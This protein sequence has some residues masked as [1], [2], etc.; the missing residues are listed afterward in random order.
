MI[1]QLDADGSY[2]YDEIHRIFPAE[3]FATLDTIRNVIL[4][5]TCRFTN[6]HIPSLESLHHII[7]KADVNHLRMSLFEQ[8][9]GSGFNWPDLVAK[10]AIRCISN[11]LGQDYLIQTKANL[12][13]QMPF[14]ETS[15]LDI[16]SDC[17]SGDS[18]WQLN[19]WIPL[20][21]STSSAS[22]FLVSRS[23]TLDYLRSL[24]QS[25]HCLDPQDEYTSL[26]SK[27]NSYPRTFVN[28]DYGQI[29]LFNPA[30]L[31]GNQLNTLDYTRFSINIRVKSLYSPD[32]VA[33]FADRG[34]GS[35]YKVARISPSG[36]FSSDVSQLL[37][38][39]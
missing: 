11:T 10:L 2:V 32:A 23:D 7:N 28:C 31:H 13:I 22:M 3:D 14:D 21:R 36:A 18:P 30:V 15:V 20:T 24:R 26:I 17:I 38:K 5:S 37:F 4:E 9:N 19:L 16:H 39:Q 33:E 6:H 12:S 34:Y 29:L 25:T 35:Y 27:L 1:E 8:I